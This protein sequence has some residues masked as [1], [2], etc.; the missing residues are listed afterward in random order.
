MFKTIRLFSLIVEDKRIIGYNFYVKKTIFGIPYSVVNED[1]PINE[2]IS[3]LLDEDVELD[4]NGELKVI[5]LEDEKPNKSKVMG[6]N[7]G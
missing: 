7:R 5:Y 4:D 1:M 2:S 3:R 6:F